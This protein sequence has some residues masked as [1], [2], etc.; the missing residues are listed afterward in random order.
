MAK[1]SV[2]PAIL[3][4]KASQLGQYSETYDS[5][6]TQLQNA[7]TTM[8]TAYDSADNRSFVNRINECAKD[9]KAMAAKLKAASVTLQKQ[10]NSYTEQETSNTQKANRLP[11]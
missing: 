6:S 9:L 4:Q 1:F 8:G 5:I 10:A 2:D 3:K 11:G 7:A